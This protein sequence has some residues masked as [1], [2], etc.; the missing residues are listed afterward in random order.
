[1]SLTLKGIWGNAAPGAFQ[2]V[3]TMADLPN[4][5]LSGLTIGTLVWVQGSQCFYQLQDVGGN[6]VFNQLALGGTVSV[7]A[8][9]NGDGSPGN[10]LGMPPADANGT[11]G[12]LTT[13]R[14]AQID[15]LPGSFVVKLVAGTGVSL[16]P[17]GG[18][19][20]VTVS[21]S[22]GSSTQPCAGFTQ[23]FDV[24]GS[25]GGQAV[26]Y[27]PDQSDY[28]PPQNEGFIGSFV[29]SSVQLLVVS[30]G[31]TMSAAPSISVGQTD[32]TGQEI[33]ATQTVALTTLPPLSYI[34]ISLA[35]PSLSFDYS[36]SSICCTLQT[37]ASGSGGA[38][39]IVRVVLTGAI[40]P[41]AWS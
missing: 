38:S 16:S 7:N 9:L 4:L 40:F 19:G 31:G 3:A 29:P 5:D 1:V 13:G 15:A 33:C 37:P 12:Y 20:V 27:T 30:R 18:T 28:F 17:S 34:N 36:G 25:S 23:N 8:P 24:F 11:D 32:G 14:C 2:S 41:I 39:C 26:F 6:L 35:N 21:A 10:P 22:A